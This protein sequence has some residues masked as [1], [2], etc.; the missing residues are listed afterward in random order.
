MT[1]YGFRP[2][3]R[4]AIRPP[5]IVALAVGLALL[6]ACGGPGR[7]L[8]ATRWQAVEIAGAPAAATDPPMLSFAEAG[9]VSGTGG[10]NAFRGE[11]RF[12]AGGGLSFDRLAGTQRACPEPAMRQELRFLQALTTVERY[13]VTGD[14]MRLFGEGE[15]P[16]L[17]FR[18]APGTV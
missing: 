2:P 15:A 7:E 9:A 6:T 16:V 17:V 14:R 18:R 10:C 8:Q 13:A 1:G 12:E 11:A 4:R 5:A 3:T